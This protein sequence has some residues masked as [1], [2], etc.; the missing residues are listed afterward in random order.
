[1]SNA[2][3]QEVLRLERVSRVY[4]Q[5]DQV[6]RALDEIDFSLH[7][8][9]FVA[10]AG[11]S[12]SGK[13]T[14]LNVA[15]GLDVPDAGRVLLKGRD[16][17]RM[18]AKE[19]AQLRLHEI[20]FIFQAYNLVPVLSAQENAEFVLLLRGMPI[21]ERRQRVRQIL[22]EVGLEGMEH[23]RPGQL[24]GGQQQRVAVARAIA[25]E[26]S[27][28]LADEPTANLDSETAF[29]LLDLMERLNREHGT[30]FLFSTHDLR[31][32]KRARRIVRL[33]DGKVER[34][35]RFDPHS[36]SRE[37]TTTHA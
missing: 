18:S 27:L 6:V 28:V 32:M 14:L 13:T 7:R 30:T 5:G 9:E 3:N 4:R 37:A 22:H 25:C 29:A 26:P 23:R 16:I 31:V 33:L 34:D 11:P 2:N 1:M 20:G 21:S 8:G 12:G 15:A 17:T 10:L 35:E 19:K 24:S 36:E